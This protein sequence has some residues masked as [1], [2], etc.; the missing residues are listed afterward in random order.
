MAWLS[1]WNNRIKLTIDKVVVAATS[2]YP[3]AYSSTYVKSTTEYDADYAP[4]YAANPY[5]SLTGVWFKNGWVS[6]SGTYTNQRFHIDLGSAKIIKRIYYENG[7]YQGT[8]TNSGVQNFTFWGSNTASGTYDD[9]VYTNDEGWTE[10]TVSQNTFDEHS[11]ADEA[12]PKYITVTNST[13]YRYYAFKF[14]DT[15]GNT[16]Y[17][18]VRQI[19]LQTMVNAELTWF[20]VAVFLDSTHGDCVFDELASDANRFKI[21]F[22]KADGETELYGEI[23]KWDDASEEAII[24]VSRD[25]WEI[26]PRNSFWTKEGVVLEPDGDFDLAIEPTVIYEGDPQILTEEDN[27]FKMWYTLYDSGEGEGVVGYAESAD[28]KDWTV[29]DSNPIL[30]VVGEMY[31]IRPFVMKY[32]STYYMYVH[33]DSEEN[34]DRYYSSDGL[35]WTKDQDNTLTVGAA[36]EWDDTY[37]GNYFVWVEGTDDWRMMYEGHS[38]PGGTYYVGYATSTDGKTWS[39][40]ASNPVLF[41]TNGA[42]GVFV[43]KVDSI[44]YMW[45]HDGDLPSDI[46]LAEST[47]LISWT[48][49][50]RNPVF[51]RSEDYEGVG[52]ADSQVSD[53]HIIEVNGTTYMFY[54]AI[55]QQ[56]T[57]PTHKIALA[58]SKLTLEQLEQLVEENTDFYMYYDADHADNTS[59][60]GD[61]DSTPGAEVWDD[62]YLM[63]CH[64]VDATAST[65][66]DSTSNS[67]DLVKKGADEPLEEN[68]KEQHFDGSDDY[69]TQATVLD[70]FPANG[71]ISIYFCPDDASESTDK[72]LFLKANDESGGSY[73]ML[74]LVWDAN[75]DDS[76]PYRITSF[77]YK[78]GVVKTLLS[79][80]A[81]NA[82][83]IYSLVTVTWGSDGFILYIDDLQED[84]DSDTNGISNGTA[85]DLIIGGYNWG[86]SVV[87]NWDGVFREFRISQNQRSIGWIKATYNSLFNNLLTYGSEETNPGWTGKICG[88]T[89]P[90]KICGISV[91]EI[92]KVSGV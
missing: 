14:A 56:A 82:S 39:K 52:D 45:Y 38:G 41:P 34:V 72:R 28:G 10:L 43:H 83:G 64:M 32:G 31:H 25:G 55:E 86:G 61:I 58:T 80:H 16:T 75:G 23:E 92:A 57:P 36:D 49:S 12:D 3:V 76:V 35:S 88:V 4:H 73:D 19:E 47:D 91:A 46:N 79:A 87:Q 66:K 9:L 17:M 7:H 54:D 1:G 85:R 65:L 21:A 48:P 5:T 37:I 24:H 20:P 89:N 6:S 50:I 27:V 69:I 26:P 2:Q 78:S 8:I 42:G 29:Y 84:S 70:T 53:P 71:A 67:Y 22:T 18:A 68:S 11:E 77:K 40:S 15:H 63:V 44:F 81:L 74:D 62:D 59:Y 30:A 51:Y 90:S 13:A 33:S 60:I